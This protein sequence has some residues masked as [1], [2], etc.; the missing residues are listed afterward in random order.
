ML[1]CYFTEV[2][3][4]S[5]YKLKIYFLAWNTFDSF[6]IESRYPYN[7]YSF[8]IHLRILMVFKEL[9]FNSMK[10]FF[11]NINHKE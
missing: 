9:Q 10:S 6:R 7:L 8:D 11:F 5:S 4:N 2:S 1:T 3:L